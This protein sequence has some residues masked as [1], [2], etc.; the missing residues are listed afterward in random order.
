MR[1]A[2][3]YYRECWKYYQTQH[4]KPEAT[5]GAAAVTQGLQDAQKK[6]A[7]FHKMGMQ[8]NAETQRQF[9]TTIHSSMKVLSKGG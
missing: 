9:E 2:Y 1:K 8:I 6:A 5:S 7:V 4:F 3:G